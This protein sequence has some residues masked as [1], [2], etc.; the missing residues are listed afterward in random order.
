[1]SPTPQRRLTRNPEGIHA[2]P[3]GDVTGASIPLSLQRPFRVIIFEWDGTA[4]ADR[5]E[6]A[7]P[8]VRVAEPLLDRGVWLVVITDT[9]FGD[10]DRQ[11]CHLIHEEKRRYLLISANRGSEVY[12]F[13]AQG[14]PL[15]VSYRATATVDDGQPTDLAGVID[16]ARQTATSTG[17]P[18]ARVTTEGNP[19]EIGLTD[20]EDALMW[21]NRELLAPEGIPFCDVIIVGD[22][23][24]TL[25]G[26]SGSND[27]A[28]ADADEA[29]IASVG[30]EPQGTPP[31]VVHLGGGPQRFRQLLSY[32]TALHT[33]A[34]H[35]GDTPTRAATATAN[36]QP[37]DHA[38][39]T[40]SWTEAAFHSADDPNW[41]LEAHAYIPALEHDIETRL[42]IGNGL[43][44]I[45]GALDM[46]TRASH[47]RTFVAGLFAPRGR[48]SFHLPALTPV[49]DW[50]SI[51][52]SVDGKRLTLDPSNVEWHRRVLDMRRGVVITEWSHRLANSQQAIRL[53][54]LRLASGA[55]RN[56]TLHTT[57][58]ALTPEAGPIEITL[59]GAPTLRAPVAKNHR[60]THDKVSE[61]DQYTE[62]KLDSMDV[63]DGILLM[64]VPGSTHTIAL[65][66]AT[67][68]WIDDKPASVTEGDSL[69]PVWTWEGQ[70]SQWATFA[71]AV[72]LAS[73]HTVDAPEN[74]A[75][76]ALWRTWREP[77]TALLQ[78]H[79][80]TW[81]E[82][83]AA[84]DIVL[85]G[86]D[87]AQVALRF[88]MYHLISA[89]DPTRNDVSIG[90]RG[91]TGEGYLGHVFWDTDIFTLPFFIFTWP[92][93]A[94][95]LLRYRYHTLPA[96]RAKAA[97][98]G[99]RGA[100]Y[101]WESADTGDEVTPPY[102]ERPDGIVLPVRSGGQE[103][104]ISADVAFA[105]WRYWQATGDDQFLLDVGAEI[106][107]ETAR[108]WASRSAVDAA[109]Q[110]HIYSV[111]GPDEYHDD[112]DDNAYT[113][114]MARW[115]LKCAAETAALLAAR[116]PARWADLS[117]HLGLSDAEL[118]SWTTCARLL[119]SPLM[120]PDGV[121]EQF[122]GYFGREDIM[123]TAQKP[124][125]LPIDLL[126]GSDRVAGSQI[127][128]QADVLML[129]ALLGE[130]YSA[131]EWEANFRYYAPRCAQGSSLSPA[132]HADIAARIGDLAAAEA[133][134]RQAM[135]IDL[136]DTLGTS[137]Q[138]VH[139]GALGG[140]WNT[141]VF[142]FLGLK[143]NQDSLRIDPHLLPSWHRLSI[144]VRWRD[145]RLVF[146]A[147][148]KPLIIRIQLQ[149]GAPCTIM[150]GKLHLHLN[151]QE[152][153][154]ARSDDDG[155]TWSEVPL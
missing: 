40:A 118:A 155:R 59:R 6:D 28:E 121:I 65:A 50:M 88:A 135:R 46:P 127:L 67:A 147:T 112:V 101:A 146:D 99:Y 19:I 138:G 39:A 72:A 97:R 94:R 82:R 53:R 152:T 100:L 57:Q 139:M 2:N 12:G 23:F 95:A 120:T 111:I 108:F 56:V 68:S 81:A 71:R 107:L 78:A 102:L 26:A 36:M 31:N 123:P 7:I 5:R 115:N 91:L 62:R 113:N 90:A 98:M 3:P 69:T 9:S 58:I 66:G 76:V 22:E 150:L 15:R 38:A 33:Q 86:D 104:H 148:Q 126:L 141:I 30:S 34:H 119:A 124:G 143:F 21:I 134:L 48:A 153:V 47:P 96:A 114:E 43:L 74:Q 64:Q 92:D 35:S 18:Q 106:L 93:A 137:A 8:L 41:L 24:G 110:R 32:Q 77:P 75:A 85:E 84:S 70:S 89:A 83:W 116:W 128:K 42:A 109:G 125:G 13:T 142:G 130:Q 29:S 44:G 4:V 133:Y 80:H 63:H 17:L 25:A 51:D 11:F 105:V 16:E 103:H 117:E 45:R 87:E 37:D 10:I 145:R 54:T 49:P 55:A 131:R 79:V 122:A 52:I 20:K 151:G 149:E 73:G 154:Q 14:S 61:R 132:V 27:R 1:M 129:L 140:L 144:P 136:S 60:Q